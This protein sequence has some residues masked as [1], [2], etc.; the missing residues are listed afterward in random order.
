MRNRTGWWLTVAVDPSWASKQKRSIVTTELLGKARVPDASFV[1]PDGTP[2]RLD[3]DYFGKKRNSE[4]P[5]PG[6]F[7]AT[8]EE[9]VSLKVRPKG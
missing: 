6:P 9:R 5:A 2:Y 7:R 8:S 1:Q 3:R 4:N